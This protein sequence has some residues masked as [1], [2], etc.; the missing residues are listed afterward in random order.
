MTSDEALFKYLMDNAIAYKDS[1]NLSLG[2]ALTAEQVAA[3]T[4]DIVWL[5]EATVNGQKVLVPVVYLAQADNRL[6]ANGA[7]II[8]NDVSLIAGGDLTNQGTLR[9]S[10]DLAATAA[11]INNSGLIE[12]SGRL[13]LLALDSIRNTQGG[14]ITGRDVSLTALTSDVINE[15]SVT[16]H[17]GSRGNRTWTQSFADSAARIEAASNLDISAGRDINNLGGSITSGSDLSMQAGRDVNL[18]SVELE[19]GRTS[20]R[21]YS[22]T[23]TQLIGDVSSG[24]DLEINA[25]RDLN[26]VA[27]RIEAARDAALSAGRDVTLASAADEQHSYDK[28]KKVTRQEDHVDQRS[29]EL[30]AGGDVLISAGESLTLVSSKIGAGNEAYLVAG[31]KIEV[32]AANDSDYSLYDKKSKGSFGKKQTRHDEVTDVKAV[33]SEITA[34]SDITLLSGGDQRYQAAKLDAG[35]DI[36]IISGGA[37]T[38]EAAKDLHQEAHEKTDNSFSWNSSKGKGSTD[39][40]VRQTQII[41]QGEIAIKAVDGLNIDYKHIDKQSVS[42]AIDAMVQADSNL[43]WLK[44]AE[45]RGDVDWRAVKEMHDSYSYSHSGLSGPAML[46]IVIIVTYFTAGAASGAIGSAAGA[47]AGSGSAMAAGTAATA[48]TAATSAGWAN[49]AL[50]AVATS[51]ASQAAISAINN[52]GDLGE[53]FTDITSSDALKNYAAAGIGAGYSPQN[54]GLQLSVNAALKTVTQGGS[55]KDNLGQAAIGLIADAVSGAIYNQVGDALVNAG[56]PTKVA[57]HALVGGLMAEAAGGDF[58]TGAMAA[59]ANEAVVAAFGEKIFPG[60]QHEK[61]LAMTSNLIGMTVA[62][63]AGGDEKSQE[64]AGWVAQQATLNNYLF[65]EELEEMATKIKGCGGEFKC[66]QGVRD[67]YADLD[68]QRNKAFPELCRTNLT[69]CVNITNQ[70]RDEDKLNVA[71]MESLRNAQYIGI[72]QAIGITYIPNNRLVDDQ[73]TLEYVR[74]TGGTAAEFKAVLAMVGAGAVGVGPKTIALAGKAMDRLKAV[75]VAKT[76]VANAYIDGAGGMSKAPKTRPYEPKGAVVLQGGAPVC[77]PACAAMTITDK[78]GVSVSL[79]KVI[80]GF[81]NGVRPTGVNTLELSDVI[82]K[83]GVKNTINTTMFPGQLNK[84]LQEGASVIVQV[85][86]GQGKHFIIVDGVKSVDGVNYYL[87]RDPY[88]G[89]RGV[90]QGLLESAMSTG[91]NAIVIGR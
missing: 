37:V 32:L 34:G 23:T 11:N 70:L 83:A 22:Q 41:A 60:D 50:T 87:T 16:V 17:D 12:S 68:D 75:Q 76:G 51:A 28:T 80:G 4:H 18:T 35:N 57:V 9:A 49:V 48:T 2:V 52:R 78:T 36:A 13:D 39:E 26:A 58:R 40:T 5:E 46:A 1:L 10:G 38:F 20:G 44:D 53:V 43:A 56:L 30:N 79:D 31:D 89:P 27:S 3:L 29:T 77:G 84:A 15:R 24:R 64:K 67:H 85:P 72:A 33:S 63:A 25:G 90:Q 47:T 61:L 71:L 19:N 66:E 69:A 62:S 6:A 81:V 73:A 42:Q 45:A 74:Q 7:L 14:I 65:H 8:G 21:N 86:A 54:F 82:S 55:F 88:V 59:G 91:V